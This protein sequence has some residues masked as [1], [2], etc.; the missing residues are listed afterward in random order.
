VPW[1]VNDLVPLT[2]TV[3]DGDFSTA[4]S[5]AWTA[6]DGVTT[7]IVTPAPVTS[8]SGVT[9]TASQLVSLDGEWIFTWNISGAGQGIERYSIWV[10]D[11]PPLPWQ[12]SLRDVAD[13][14]PTRTIS[15]DSTAETPL[16]TFDTTTIPQGEQV[17]RQ[18]AAAVRWV[19]AAIGTVPPDLYGSAQDVAAVRSAA[20]VEL[21]Y[22]QNDNN[23]AVAETLLSQANAM[24]K[25]L[26][27]A[28]GRESNDPAIYLF[29]V[30][31][32][33]AATYVEDI[34]QGKTSDWG[35]QSGSII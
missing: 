25:E 11:T 6:P 35:G 34:P 4:T 22:P 12:P 29:P 24:L 30:G 5:V 26:E 1:N 13:Y 19:T 31:A 15:V 32:F 18:I 10:S 20:L 2:L 27:V 9:W 33:P 14:V 17:Y 28:V 21:S 3:P 16:M 8:D 7:G 23:V